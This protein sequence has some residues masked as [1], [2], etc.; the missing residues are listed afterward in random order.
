MNV[1][2]NPVFWSG[3][4]AGSIAGIVICGV[5]AAYVIVKHLHESITALSAI[6]AVPS[7]PTRRKETMPNPNGKGK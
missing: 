3:F 5:L 7:M 4:Y 2:S 6:M 1:L